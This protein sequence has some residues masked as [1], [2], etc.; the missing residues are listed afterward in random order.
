MFF[1][2]ECL[3][4][5]IIKERIIGISMNDMKLSILTGC[6]IIMNAM[7]RRKITCR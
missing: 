6:E 7:F 3:T 5:L 4:Q 2:A 1:V